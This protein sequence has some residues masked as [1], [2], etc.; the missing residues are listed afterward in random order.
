MHP[1]PVSRRRFLSLTGAASAAPFLGHF[2]GRAWALNRERPDT[3]D[4]VRGINTFAGELHAQLAR[5]SK[6]SLFFSPFSIETA[7]AMTSA[8]ARGET[9]VEMERTLHLPA[10][11]HPA[12]SE[13]LAK[14]NGTG[15]DIKRPYE[16]TTAN[17]IWAQQGFPWR[18]EFVG[19]MTT[20]Y[21]SGLIEVDFARSEAARKQINNWVAKE[22]KE[23][24]QDLIGEGVITALTRM[25][26]T[27]AIYFKG[28]WQYQFNKNN[29]HTAPFTRADGTRADVPLM[30][31]SGHFKYGQAHIG[32]RTGDEVQFLELPYTRGDLSM[33]V[34]LPKEPRKIERLATYLKDGN[35]SRT[36]MQME[37]VK[38]WLPRFK[39]ESRFRLNTP[40]KELGMK[41]AFGGEADFSGLSP[42]AQGLSI[43]DVIHK[44]F[45]DVNEE[46]TEAAAATAVV[47]K[48]PAAPRET[49]FR[50]DRPFI[51]VIRDNRS[52][53]A[54]FMGRYMGPTK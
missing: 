14:V 39:A 8:G 21:G 41:K 19:L 6:D 49:M 44:A 53:T 48:E 18:K 34:L 30:H 51:Y 26:L 16:L 28:T 40:L 45:V 5:D 4:L 9:L 17:A 33:L 42:S 38:I 25:V 7:L 15:L 32:G 12:F 54:L 36:E 47:V 27:N 43:S 46:G 29:T 1:F 20:T 35:F 31:Q 50:A 24:I 10:D 23:K 13:L 3:K 52:G 22:T 2:G 11:P 37:S